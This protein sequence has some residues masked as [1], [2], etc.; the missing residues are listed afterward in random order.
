MLD[1]STNQILN[2]LFDIANNIQI[3]P[4]F[5]IYHPNYQPFALPTNIA[6]RFQQNSPS[7]KQKYLNILLRNFLYGIYY[8]GSLQT[9]LAT[10]SNCQSQIHFL[11]NNSLGVDEEFY[12]QLHH[13]N[14]GTGYYEP[15][16]QILRIE[17]DGSMA[18][19]KDGLTLYIEPECH[20]Q[21][22]KK[23]PKVGELIA[24]W[25]PKN[26]LQNGCYVAVSNTAIENQA[27]QNTDL[28]GGRIYF[29]VRSSGAIVLMDS[30][31]K[32]LN[33][34]AIAFSFQVLYNPAAYQRY[35]AGVLHFNRQDYPTIRNILQDIYQK[36]QAYF[37]PEI[38]LFTKFLAP[39]LGLAEE[40]N[41]KFAPQE[42]FGM[43]RCQIIANALLE[44]WQRGK[45]ALEERIEL[46]NQH[47]ARN[48]IDVQHPYL[49]PA[50]EDIYQPLI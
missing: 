39:G 31:T 32:A 1:D 12:E 4:N 28:G 22:Q 48:L 45:N 33:N 40:P 49:N 5:C 17:P 13:R 29:H 21:P 23:S 47:F 8:N 3:E 25:M 26:R 10:N 36:H 41:Q 27:P 6:N 18:V 42:S 37:Q 44:S 15:N 46:I 19:N 35:D 30:L 24:I 14:H 2:S 50:S 16:W 34:V 20:L 43:N 7:L 9:V 38:P 11:E